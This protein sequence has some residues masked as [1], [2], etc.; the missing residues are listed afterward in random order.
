M[1][2][3]NRQCCR[4]QS[5][6]KS[7]LGETVSAC[8]KDFVPTSGLLNSARTARFVWNRNSLCENLLVSRKLVLCPAFSSGCVAQWWSTM[9]RHG[10]CGFDSRRSR[11]KVVSY[12]V[13]T[14][15]LQFFKT[16]IKL[17]ESWGCQILK[18]TAGQ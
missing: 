3:K 2:R 16:Q 7:T 6:G 10:G 15:F 13:T 5:F 9:H 1:S 17:Q 12:R 8:E 4:S 14:F 18:P 11:F